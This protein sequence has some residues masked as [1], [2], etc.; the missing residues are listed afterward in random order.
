MFPFQNDP[1]Y[2]SLGW[3][4]DYTAS[5]DYTQL[6]A[7]LTKCN[8]EQQREIETLKTQQTEL[9]TRVTALENA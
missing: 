1:D 9:I 3:T 5:L 7:Y 4:K 6:F 2:A 8:Q